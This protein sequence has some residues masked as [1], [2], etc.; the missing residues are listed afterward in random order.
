M[1][2]SY[3]LL[4][5]LPNPGFGRWV[6]FPVSITLP[7]GH[8]S[9]VGSAVHH[10]GPLPRSQVL[11]DSDGYLVTSPARTAVDLAADLELPQAL[12]LLDGAARPICASFVT[13]PLRR[14]Y[15]NPTYV[16]AALA[17][18]CEAATTIRATRARVAI[19]L[20]KPCRESAAARAT[21][22]PDFLWEEQRLIGECE[23]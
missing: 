9:K 16:S 20:T 22:F 1:E 21:Y 11:A 2:S 4:P 12:V 13:K 17:L 7:T 23:G 3:A 14:D 6:E 5:G 8:V 18:L 15:V 10:V 19:S